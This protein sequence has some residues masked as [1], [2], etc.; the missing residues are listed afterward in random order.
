[1]IRALTN[2]SKGR[3]TS[4]SARCTKGG[5]SLNVDIVFLLFG[6]FALSMGANEEQ[7]TGRDK[8]RKKK[9]GSRRR[10]HSVKRENHQ[11]KKWMR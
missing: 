10:F 7:E 1:M 11:L 6:I 9:K 4:A 2:Q 8:K 5:K 3:S